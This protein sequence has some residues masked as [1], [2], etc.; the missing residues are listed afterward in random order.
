MSMCVAS[1]KFGPSSEIQ[2]KLE[3]VSVFHQST[4]MMNSGNAVNGTMEVKG[5]AR[6]KVKTQALSSQPEVS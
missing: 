1:E 5:T 3:E 4:F 2:Q 6:P